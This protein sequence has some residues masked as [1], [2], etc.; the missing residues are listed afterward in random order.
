M[1][2]IWIIVAV[3]ITI[4]APMCSHA[5]ATTINGNKF[6]NTNPTITRGQAETSWGFSVVPTGKA[7]L[8]DVPVI[9]TIDGRH[10]GTVTPVHGGTET[11]AYTLTAAQT[12][13]LSTGNHWLRAWFGGNSK[14]KACSM[15]VEVKV[16]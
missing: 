1:N 16:R 6:L 8:L 7:Q 14:Y 3:C 13:S 5:Q 15:T 9:V 10:I 11:C 4:F 12:K 2:I